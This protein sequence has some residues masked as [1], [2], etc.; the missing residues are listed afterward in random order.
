[1]SFDPRLLR[2]FVVLAED[3][4]FGRAAERLNLAQPALSQQIR[5]LEAQVGVKLYTRNSRVVELTGPGRA[6]LGPARAA[7]RAA[8]QAERAA[9]EAQWMSAHQLKVGVETGLE[10][11]VAPVLEYAQHHAEVALWLSRMHEPQGHEVLATSQI[12]AFIGFLPPTDGSTVPR[13]RAI[14]ISFSA[15]MRA[16]HPLARRP[17]VTLRSLRE[18]PIAIFGRRQSP[19]L[20]DRFVEVLSEG[21]GPQSLTLREPEATGTSSQ[22]AVLRE[23]SGGHAVSFGTSATLAA[24]AGDLRSVPFDPPLSVPTYVSWHAER[25]VFVDALVEHLRQPS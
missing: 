8:A 25:S 4:H 14:D 23:V 7:L 19:E 5:R 17:A 18:S 11:M 12:D 24:G 13:V 16:D 10:D 1:M 9:K 3:L 21:Q 6:M 20:F 2:S 22:I 15:V